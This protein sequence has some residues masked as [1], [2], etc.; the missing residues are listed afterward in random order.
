MTTD[1]TSLHDFPPAGQK[2][3]FF[4]EGT[5]GKRGGRAP[6]LMRTHKDPILGF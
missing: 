2:M 6:H 5:S 1:S 3:I 4:K